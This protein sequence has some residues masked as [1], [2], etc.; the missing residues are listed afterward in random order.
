VISTEAAHS[1]IISSGS[2]ISA[3]AAHSH[4]VSGAVEK[5]ASLPRLSPATHRSCVRL[6]RCLCR[7]PERSEGSRNPPL[8]TALRA[9]PPGISTGAAFFKPPPMIVIVISTGATHSLIVSSAVEKSAS[10]PR[11]SPATHRSYVR[12]CRHPER[13]EGSRDPPF[14]TTLWA[15]SPG[16]STGAAFFKPPHNYDRHFDRRY[17]QPH[18]EQRGGEI[19]FSPTAESGHPS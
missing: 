18:R 19:C 9:F 6:C 14:P 7:H 13:S 17:S 12:P 16:I 10:H 1:L 15:F 11:L 8:P 4:I 5:S 2:V 3:E